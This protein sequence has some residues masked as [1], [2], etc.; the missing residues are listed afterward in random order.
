MLEENGQTG[1]N[2]VEVVE[3]ILRE[4]IRIARP[5]GSD[6]FT[7]LELQVPHIAREIFLRLEGH[8]RKG[9]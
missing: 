6:D 5:N 4:E 7:F 3:E 2:A 9:G 8:F 1:A